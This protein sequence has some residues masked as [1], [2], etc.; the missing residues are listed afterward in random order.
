MILINVN[1]MIET[2]LTKWVA[3]KPHGS[4]P[5]LVISIAFFWPSRL[6]ISLVVGP[7]PKPRRFA[8]LS[9]S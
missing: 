7:V 1:W 9:L 8:E 6:V 2:Y 4:T 3:A 5:L